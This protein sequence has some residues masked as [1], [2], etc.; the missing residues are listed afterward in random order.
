MRTAI[1]LSPV[2]IWLLGCGVPSQRAISALKEQG[3]L[4]VAAIEEHIMENGGRPSSLAELELGA[5]SLTTRYGPWV[6]R[7]VVTDRASGSTCYELSVGDYGRDGFILC[8]SQDRTEWV[9]DQ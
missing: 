4:I 7:E 1:A 5:E 6:Y 9:L 2:L 8:Y 3:N